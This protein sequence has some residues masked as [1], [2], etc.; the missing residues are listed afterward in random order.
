MPKLFNQRIFNSGLNEVINSA[1]AGTLKMTL[2]AA[3]PVFATLAANS[4]I[5]P[6]TLAT[7]DLTLADDGSG[8]RQI[9]VAQKTAVATQTVASGSDL[10][11]TLYDNTSIL[12]QTT[13][14][15]HQAITTGGTLLF[16]ALVF[17]LSA[18]I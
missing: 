8:G 1:T 17:G 18:P 16:P 7:I 14:A 5:T 2:T 3:A 11:V 10:H 4:L 12:A 13:E 15:T 6:I 9:T